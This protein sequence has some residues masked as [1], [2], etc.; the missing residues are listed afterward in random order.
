MKIVVFAN[1]QANPIGSL[2]EIAGSGIEAIR[3]PPVH[4]ISSE[5]AEK[6]YEMVSKSD[7]VV[8]QPIGENFGPISSDHLRSKFSSKG[9]VSFPSIYFGGLFPQLIYLRKP[10]GGTLRGPLGD[11]HDIRIIESFISGLSEV[12]C[13]ERIE[14]DDREYGEQYQTAL[15]ESKRRDKLVDVPVMDII[16][17]LMEIERP[18]NTFNHPTTAVIWQVSLRILGHLGIRKKITAKQPFKKFL[19]EITAMIPQTLAEKVS[20]GCWSQQHYERK[21][22][23]L[24]TTQLVSD[25]FKVYRSEHDFYRLYQHNVTR[26]IKILDS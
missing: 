16:E 23:V 18:L 13:V 22:E 7:V 26:K 12:G 3:C 24:D 15:K 11:Y 2:L 14:Y 25:F 9:F 19:N 20:N 8:H 1:C 4:T 5:D 6:L 10:G 21:G 17:E